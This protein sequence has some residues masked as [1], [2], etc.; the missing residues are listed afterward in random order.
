MFF[1]DF[2]PPKKSFRGQPSVDGGQQSFIILPVV[3]CTMQHIQLM[4][5]WLSIN[6]I[7]STMFDPGAW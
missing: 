7:V 5:T 3:I 2:T 6:F 1:K 4:T